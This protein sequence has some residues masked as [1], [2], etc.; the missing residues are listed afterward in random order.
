M[1]SSYHINANSTSNR[2]RK[3]AMEKNTVGFQALHPE[4]ATP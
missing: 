1:F 4:G 3:G 2:L